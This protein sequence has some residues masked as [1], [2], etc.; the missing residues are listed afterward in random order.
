LPESAR[1]FSAEAEQAGRE[2][3][4]ALAGIR[5]LAGIV[6]GRSAAT[7]G[8]SGRVAALAQSLALA[9]GWSH[10]RAVL[11]RDVAL[12]HDVGKIGLPEAILLKPGPL[13]PEERRQI[14]GHPGVGAEIVTGVLG[15]EQVAWLRHHHERFDGGGYPDGLRGARIP[16]GARLL[17]LADAWDAMTSHR[18][19]Q[20]AKTPEQALVECRGEAGLHFCPQAVA[21]LGRLW[22]EGAIAPPSADVA[23]TP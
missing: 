3:D 12:V 15:V 6:D 22:D 11:L 9:C 21:A 18:P 10:D 4:Q 5:S 1:T 7:R 14:C 17:A 19:Y 20:A 16:L 8:H 2:R 23:G 13:D